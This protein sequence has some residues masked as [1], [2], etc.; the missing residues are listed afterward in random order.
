VLRFS[1]GAMIFLLSCTGKVETASIGN[2]IL[3]DYSQ[4]VFNMPFRDHSMVIVLNE[5]TCNTCYPLVLQLVSMNRARSYII[6]N[7]PYSNVS[8]VLK[9][10]L[11][12]AKKHNFDVFIDKQRV[13]S[14]I[15]P[16][17]FYPIIFR[18]D[19]SL[20]SSDVFEINSSGFEK[21]KKTFF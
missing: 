21:I 19:N 17:M 5:A 20:G 16:V 10:I 4:N 15:Y 3:V 2:N 12:A 8:P 11:D 1:L 18:F 14:D 13:F 9:E 7:T 6:F